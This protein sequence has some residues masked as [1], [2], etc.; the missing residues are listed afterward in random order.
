MEIIVTLATPDGMVL[1]KFAVV[2]PDDAYSYASYPIHMMSQVIREGIE[3]DF[4]TRDL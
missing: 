2:A 4:E 1:Y 3:D